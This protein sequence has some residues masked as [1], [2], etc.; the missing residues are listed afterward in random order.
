MPQQQGVADGNRAEKHPWEPGSDPRLTG[1]PPAVAAPVPELSPQPCLVSPQ[2]RAAAGWSKGRLLL[3]EQPHGKAQPLP[4]PL[5][6]PSSIPMPAARGQASNSPSFPVA[7]LRLRVLEPVPPAPSVAACWALVLLGPPH[8]HSG[9][10]W[11][12]QTRARGAGAFAPQ[13]T[14]A[15]QGASALQRAKK[16]QDPR[17]QLCGVAFCVLHVHPAA[18]QHEENQPWPWLRRGAVGLL[19]AP[20]PS[21]IS[22][23]ATGCRDL[24]TR[25]PWVPPPLRPAAKLHPPPWLGVA[26]GPVPDFPGGFCAHGGQSRDWHRHGLAAQHPE[27]V[28]R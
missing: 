26:A 14:L 13:S 25:S 15:L 21:D 22:S 19:P 16:E 3:R 17:R 8:G 10:E 6:V 24:Y 2:Q 20:L 7:L 9:H 27:Q 23:E 1:E 4:A 5:S 28:C 12:H 18:P 11:R